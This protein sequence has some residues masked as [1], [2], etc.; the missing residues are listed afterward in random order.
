MTPP[1][2]PACS[3]TALLPGRSS[4]VLVCPVTE[5]RNTGLFPAG[6]FIPSLGHGA[7]EPQDN[8]SLPKAGLP[9]QPG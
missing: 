5:K 2:T 7:E 9:E 1:I 4:S 8:S 6:T 3:D